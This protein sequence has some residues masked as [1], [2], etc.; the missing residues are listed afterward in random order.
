RPDYEV[1]FWYICLGAEFDRDRGKL[2]L[3]R[4]RVANLIGAEPKNFR[5]GAFFERFRND[6]LGK[7]DFT[8]HG[9]YKKHCRTLARLDLGAFNDLVTEELEGRL[10][11]L[12]RV[13]LDGSKV[14]ARKARAVRAAEKGIA[15]SRPAYGSE[16]LFIQNYLN[17]LHSHLFTQ[18]L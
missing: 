1:F 9:W 3:C 10:D 13:Y 4:N 5:S 2:L 14:T 17:S 11:R 12:K 7:K 6:L 8:W 18:N 15:N 16:A